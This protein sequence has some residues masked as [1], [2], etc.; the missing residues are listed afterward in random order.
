VLT[1][2]LYTPYGETPYRAACPLAALA[3]LPVFEAN[4]GSLTLTQI[5]T[6]A[7]QHNLPHSE[8]AVAHA[9]L[10]LADA[11]YLTTTWYA[12]KP[13]APDWHTWPAPRGLAELVRC[14]LPNRLAAKIAPHY[15]VGTFA[16]LVYEAEAGFVWSSLANIKGFGRTSYQAFCRAVGAWRAEQTNRRA[17]C[18]P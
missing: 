8:Q 7:A 6:L 5:R 11:G 13:P 18:S 2:Q 3:Y 10:L 12:A 14:G 17:P 15:Q 4:R 1:F 9:T 16:C